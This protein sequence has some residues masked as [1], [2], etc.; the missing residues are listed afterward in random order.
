M[1][2]QVDPLRSSQGIDIDAAPLLKA[3]P[4]SVTEGEVVLHRVNSCIGYVLIERQIP[5]G[6]EFNWQFDWASEDHN[7]LTILSLK[8]MDIDRPVAPMSIGDAFD[9]QEA[10]PESCSTAAS[11]KI[12]GQEILHSGFGNSPQ[13]QGEIP[14]GY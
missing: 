2:K 11:E 9:R 13:D 12:A 3:S 14:L 6:I 4:F 8:A 5:V 10:L 7:I 1:I